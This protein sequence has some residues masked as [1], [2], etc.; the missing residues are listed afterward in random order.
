ML[1]GVPSEIKVH[2]YRVG[3]TPGAV[4]EYIARGHRFFALGVEGNGY[5]HRCPH[6]KLAQIHIGA[7]AAQNA[8]ILQRLLP[9][10][11]CT[12]RK[13]SRLAQFLLRGSTVSDERTE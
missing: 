4:R 6:A 2:E 7:I 9:P 13:P 1:V 5:H 3:L 11:R 8:C 12:G 10:R